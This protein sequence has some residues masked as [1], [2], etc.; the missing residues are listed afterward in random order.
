MY[1]RR[2]IDTEFAAWKDSAKR[3]PLI[4]R[5]VRQCGKTEAVRHLGES[6]EE[7]I[8]INLEKDVHLQRLFE[9]K[10]DIEAILARFE[11]ESGKDIAD[12]KTLLFLDEIQ[13]CPKAITAL[14]YFYE[15]RPNLHLIAAG[16]L[17]EFALN[18][19]NQK[20]YQFPVG[21]VRSIYMYPFSY[22]EYLTAVGQ[23][24]LRKWIED[25]DP[26]QK[27]NTMHDLLLKH[28]KD[29]LIVGGMPEAVVTFAETHSF[30]ECQRVH[31]DIV[32]N[33]KEDFEK[34]GGNVSAE[35]LRL[36]FEHT[37]HNACKQ[38][39]A[40]SAVAGMSAYTFNEA[41]ALLQR[42]GL[43]IPVNA[44]SCDTLPLGSGEKASNRKTIPFDTGIFL[45]ELGLDAGAI[46]GSEVFD[47]LN[48]G[49]LAE[50]ATG[51]EWIKYTDPYQPAG[52]FYW[53]R[54]GA[55]AE[56]DYIIQ[57]KKEIIP[58]EVK[59]SVK[60]GMKSLQ[61]FLTWKG[62]SHGI[63]ASLENF[64]QYGKIQVIPLYAVCTL[65]PSREGTDTDL[66]Q[67]HL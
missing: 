1:I 37:L 32:L 65:Y 54:S 23:T 38:V 35:S 40:S 42:A 46:L 61:S 5:G 66:E 47:D 15:E 67:N 29:F 53:Y 25:I 60:G 27:E 31:R 64:A 16:S 43:V 7:Y 52:L 63:R 50:I 55:N 51:L 13:E 34:Y 49:N 18:K 12:G 22:K 24:K 57:Q 44:T 21:R 14:R 48:K 30:L 56:V 20:G 36:V 11:V 4:L 59:A 3:K 41:Y 28:Y 33:F 9:G 17:L 62:A 39:R 8:E 2:D 26:L 10:I 19:K 58:L 6:F 45:T